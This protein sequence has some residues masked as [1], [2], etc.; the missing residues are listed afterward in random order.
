MSIQFNL[1]SYAKVVLHALKYPSDSVGG[2][3]IGE[4]MGQDLKVNDVVPVYH[5]PPVSPILEIA[6]IIT[7]Q[8]FEGKLEIIGIYFANERADSSSI[9]AYIPSIVAAIEQGSSIKRCSLVQIDNEKIQFQGLSCL[10]SLVNGQVVKLMDSTDVVSE[11]IEK[12]LKAH[13]ERT[14]V[15]VQDH[16][17]YPYPDFRNHPI[18]SALRS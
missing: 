3:L 14:L 7:Q 18:V 1:E 13:V 17:E 11:A 4:I 2:F 6:S 5:G 15:D 16:F 12:L 9:P 8:I 10:S